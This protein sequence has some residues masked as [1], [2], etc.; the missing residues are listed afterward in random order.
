MLSLYTQE[1]YQS[2]K[3]KSE[4]KS[5]PLY[6]IPVLSHHLVNQPPLFS[7]YERTLFANC[8][9][10]RWTAT[11]V[12]AVHR[13]K[14]EMAGYFAQVKAEDGGMILSSFVLSHYERP[15]RALSFCL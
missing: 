8:K 10:K 13:Y 2:R 14:A 4:P 9:E 15:P 11:D 3:S 7:V 5:T 6:M 1:S 12:G